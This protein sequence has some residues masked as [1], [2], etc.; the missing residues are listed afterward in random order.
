M[1]QYLNKA[2]GKKK[3]TAKKKIQG[4]CEGEMLAPEKTRVCVTCSPM[5]KPELTL[6]LVKTDMKGLN[7]KM[8]KQG[9][10]C[11]TFQK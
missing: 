3:N 11:P 2:E 5:D 6:G 8:M 1:C 7:I 9:A 4:R 10:L